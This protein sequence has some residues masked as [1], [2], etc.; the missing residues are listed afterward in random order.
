MN[1]PLHPA[2]TAAALLHIDMAAKHDAELGQAWLRA[3][4]GAA[5]PRLTAFALALSFTLAGIQRF[6]QPVT[7][8]LSCSVDRLLLQRSGGGREGRLLPPGG[9]SAL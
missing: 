6:E 2:P 9:H 7:G 5:P 8:S 3:L 4:R 1:H